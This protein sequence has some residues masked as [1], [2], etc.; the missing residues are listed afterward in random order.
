[1]GQQEDKLLTLLPLNAFYGSTMCC[2]KK[3]LGTINQR[4]TSQNET[5]DQFSP[6]FPTKANFM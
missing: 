3:K 6:N 2:C 1:M 5:F 4:I